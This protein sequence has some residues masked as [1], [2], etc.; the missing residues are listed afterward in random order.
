MGAFSPRLG[1]GAVFFF[2][3]CGV[4]LGVGIKALP[5]SLIT[6]LLQQ[7]K[8][9]SAQGQYERAEELLLQALSYEPN[10]EQ[11]RL[12][13]LTLASNYLRSGE[14]DQAD[15]IIRGLK[16]MDAGAASDIETKIVEAS[17]HQ[18][19]RDYDSALSTLAGQKTDT[20]LF[21]SAYLLELTGQSF[22]AVSRLRELE[23]NFPGSPYFS[24]THLALANSFFTLQEYES[25]QEALG[26]IQRSGDLDLADWQTF[27]S[28]LNLY[29]L[30]RPKE[31]EVLLSRLQEETSHSELLPTVAL[32]KG[33]FFLRAGDFASAEK[34]FQKNLTTDNPL[35]LV[36][37]AAGLTD[38]YL[39]TERPEEA[40][41][42]LNN[43]LRKSLAEEDRGQLLLLRGLALQRANQIQSAL[44]DLAD[45]I[46]Q[47]GRRWGRYA[48]VFTAQILWQRNDYARLVGD[49]KSQLEAF[50][51]EEK[52]IAAQ[53][54]QDAVDMGVCDLAVADAHYAL[55]Q[56]KQA[57]ILYRDLLALSPTPRVTVQ[58]ISGLT[59]SL[60][61]QKQYEE[62]AKALDEL[63]VRYGEDR[64]VIR[65]GLL[66]Q[67]HLS[68]DQ[69]RTEEAMVMYDRYVEMFP[70]DEKA[71]Q[72]L[73]QKGLCQ[74]RGE[75]KKEALQTWDSLRTRYPASPYAF[76][77]LV[78]SGMVAGE[79]GDKVLADSYYRELSRMG[80]S[81]ESE[82]A[83]LQLGINQL[84]R[85][86][87]CEAIET[88]HQFT[89]RF[90]SSSQM[91]RVADLI[92]Q[93]YL[94]ISLTRPE[95]LEKLAYQ[96]EK[97]FHGGEAFFHQGLMAFSKSDYRKAS[98][99]FRRVCSDFPRTPSVSQALFYE[100]ESAYQAGR[101]EKAAHILGPFLRQYP[102]H[103]LLEVAR[104][105][106]AKS[107]VKIGFNDEAV[108]AFQEIVEK[109]PQST[110]A[111]NALFEW[112]SLLEKK[113]EADGAITVFEAFLNDFPRHSLVNNVYWRLGQ[114]ERR[115][116]AY[117]AALTYL[118]RV[119][120]AAGVATQEEIRETVGAVEKALAKERATP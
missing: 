32:V 50:R 108:L 12:L 113:N 24:L 6:S 72:A 3:I 2:F 27:L 111:A 86:L 22:A 91:S 110:F 82:L 60:V 73:Y 120:P 21:Q 95:E 10:T 100:G 29:H 59:S 18:A 119:Q 44:D 92:K 68:W 48:L 63:V 8:G 99:N 107:L 34:E 7:A 5:P 97:A 9:A 58:A 76:R 20:A 94:Q 49:F 79:L 53:N 74:V 37:S 84:D 106:R 61:M 23:E 54:P 104:F 90:P 89:G 15:L 115:Q 36:Q 40:L 14:V 1:I 57:E 70:Q 43:V 26:S 56:Y 4:A 117:A 62:A 17:I 31:A 105:H 45:V 114:L 65:F 16:S 52:P 51:K 77:A 67:A 80:N 47:E 25:A 69:G 83:M 64:E 38:I 93:S 118:G 81:P 102:N 42:V 109:S 30:Q 11:K 101:Y 46:K 88:F 39:R 75:Q 87:L 112:A 85:N 28:A 19:R 13:L 103:E 33:L 96:Y 35:C 71:P 116:G 66:T 41:G 98:E 78:R 55:E